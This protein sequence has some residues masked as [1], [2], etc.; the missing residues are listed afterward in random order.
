MLV[1]HDLTMFVSY[2][3]Q[4]LH[5]TGEVEILHKQTSVVRTNCMDCL[6]RTN[7]V[8]SAIAREV[9]VKQLRS[10]GI[11]GTNEILQ[12]YAQLESIFRHIWADNANA[13]S[14]AYSG[15]GA[16]K[17]DFTRTGKRSKA[18]MVQDVINSLVR[19]VMNNYMDGR[20]QASMIMNH[21]KCVNLY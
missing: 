16:L 8:Q 18:G 7:V 11:I 19:Y 5:N 13:I 1:F 21:F 15:T 3:E 9:L 20:R 10:T 6:D 12:N 17:T 2:F 14:V 4:V